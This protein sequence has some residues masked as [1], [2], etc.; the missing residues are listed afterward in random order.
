MAD[1]RYTDNI[2]TNTRAIHRQQKID[3][4]LAFA[5]NHPLSHGWEF[6]HRNEQW[7]QPVYKLGEAKLMFYKDNWLVEYPHLETP[8]FYQGWLIE[9]VTEDVLKELSRC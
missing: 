2:F 7:D 3:R 5:K 9:S 4:Q 6:S 8:V 1:S